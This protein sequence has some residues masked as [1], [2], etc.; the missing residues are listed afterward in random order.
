MLTILIS[1]DAYTPMPLSKSPELNAQTGHGG[2]CCHRYGSALS[3]RE[4]EG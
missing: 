4:S 2:G 1:L 3:S